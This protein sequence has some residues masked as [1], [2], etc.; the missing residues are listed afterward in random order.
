MV[1]WIPCTLCHITGRPNACLWSLATSFSLNR[2]C[3]IPQHSVYFLSLPLP[4]WRCPSRVSSDDQEAWK[5]LVSSSTVC[6]GSTIRHPFDMSI[7][8]QLHCLH[9]ILTLYQMENSHFSSLDLAFLNLMSSYVKPMELSMKKPR[10]AAVTLSCTGDHASHWV[11]HMLQLVCRDLWRPGENRITVVNECVDEC[12]YRITVK[13][14]GTAA[15]AVS[16]TADFQG[17]CG[18]PVVPIWSSLPETW[19]LGKAD[20]T[21]LETTEITELLRMEICTEN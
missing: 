14:N 2:S 1:A 13:S 10:Q 20:I 6:G 8:F 21:R 16:I 11:Q 5:W 19:T 3:C 9:N 17:I 12:R 15:T 7:P 4:L 18:V